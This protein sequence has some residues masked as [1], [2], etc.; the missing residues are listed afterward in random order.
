[1]VGK[2]VFGPSTAKVPPFFATTLMVK[3]VEEDVV[4]EE[5]LV[6]NDD[7]DVWVA[8]VGVALSTRNAT[9]EFVLQIAL[10]NQ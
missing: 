1:M 2:F 9:I 4:D 10:Q 8:G 6:D 7:D 3:T 5:V